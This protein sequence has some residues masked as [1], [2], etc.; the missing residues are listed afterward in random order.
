MSL[1]LNDLGLVDVVREIV[2]S[3]Q[4]GV[5]HIVRPSSIASNPFESSDNTP[6]LVGSF[7]L[8]SFKD[9]TIHERLQFSSNASGI[10]RFKMAIPNAEVLVGDYAFINWSEGV[11]IIPAVVKE[12]NYNLSALSPVTV[13]SNEGVPYTWTQVQEL[14]ADG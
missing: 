3:L 11:R 2:D 8:I 1:N 13:N 9:G 4:A 7:P 6:L 14:L 5:V 12:V 10:F